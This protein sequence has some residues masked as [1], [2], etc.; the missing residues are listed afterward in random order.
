MQLVDSHREVKK[1]ITALQ[2]TLERQFE[3]D[4]CPNTALGGATPHSQLPHDLL[5]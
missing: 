5:Y 1:L 3:A 4:V 2:P